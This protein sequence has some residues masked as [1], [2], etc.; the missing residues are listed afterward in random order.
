[1]IYYTFTHT[2]SQ[3]VISIGS[4]ATKKLAYARM[5]AETKEAITVENTKLT[6]QEFLQ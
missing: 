4:G 2:S 1:M 5:A 3:G 6:K